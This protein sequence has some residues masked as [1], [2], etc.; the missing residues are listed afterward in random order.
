MPSSTEPCRAASV[1]IPRETP[2]LA[3]EVVE[4]AHAEEGV[5]HDQDRPALADHL[6]RAGDRADLVVVRSV[7]HLTEPS[8][9]EVLSSN[10]LRC[11]ARTRNRRLA[12]RPQV[13]GVRDRLGRRLHGGPRPLHRQHRVP[14]HPARL[15]RH[16]PR[17]P[18]LDPERLRDRVRRAARAGGPD[19][20]PRR[21]QARLPRRPRRRSSSRPPLCAAAPS[22]E[23]LVGGARAAGGGRRLHGPDLARPA[24]ARVP[25]RAARHRRGRLGG[26]RRRRR[27]GR[28]AD[29]RPARRG[30]LALGVPRE[31]AGR[32]RRARRSRSRM[33]QR[34]A[35]PG[36]GPAARP[37]RR[38]DAGRRHRD[39]S[40]SG[41]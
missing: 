27:R 28:P 4:A 24:A 36:P 41:S 3:L 12:A 9:D 30:E 15:R 25:A 10:P 6:E 16:E 20:R 40:C 26:G 39:C 17:R 8:T 22:V 32:A 33:L 23:V 7:K 35:R 38:G 18:L 11:P 21:A 13:A 37:A 5:A 29:R 34:A 31:R 2:R 14:G 19:L 1:R